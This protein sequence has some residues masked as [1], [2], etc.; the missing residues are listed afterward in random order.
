MGSVAMATKLKFEVFDVYDRQET[1]VCPI[2]QAHC[3]VMGLLRSPD[4]SQRHDIIFDG[5]VCGYLTIKASKVS[6][7]FDSHRVLYILVRGRGSGG[8]S[9]WE[10]EGVGVILVGGRGSGGLS[11]WEGEGVGGLSLWEGEGVGVILVGGRVVGVELHTWVCILGVI[12]PTH[13]H[14]WNPESTNFTD[15]VLFHSEPREWCVPVSGGHPPAPPV[16]R[17]SHDLFSPIICWGCGCR[18]GDKR[19]LQ[20]SSSHGQCC[21]T[22]IPIPGQVSWLTCSIK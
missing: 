14:M 7:F 9:L 13:T 5:S 21:H 22:Y 20:L 18:G 10:G 19:K 4:Q 1:K 6:W 15:I 16:A 2:G 12:P 8:L 17:E 3:Q 11:L